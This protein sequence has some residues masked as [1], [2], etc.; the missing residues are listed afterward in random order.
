MNAYRTVLVYSGAATQVAKLVT[1]SAR[2]AAAQ[3]AS[4]DALCPPDGVDCDALRR[5][6]GQAGAPGT[7]RALGEGAAALIEHTRGADLLVLSQPYFESSQAPGLP[8]ASQ[9]LVGASCPLLFVPRPAELGTRCASRVLVAWDGGRESARALRDALP[10]LQRA[11][12]VAMYAYG[13]SQAPAAHSLAHACE[14]LRRHGVEP[15]H[16]VQRMGDADYARGGTMAPTLLDAS[17]GE[18]LLSDAADLDA[19]LLVMGAYGHS[20][21]QELVLGG[22]TR[23]LLSSMTLPVLMSH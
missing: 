15:R 18:L 20:P 12:T 7:C 17:V 21:K 6:L 8:F 16:A 1:L 2:L 22:V 10:L 3:G 13:S 19:D 11:D 9:L 14:Y 23:S 5:L 4:I